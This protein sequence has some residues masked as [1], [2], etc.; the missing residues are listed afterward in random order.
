MISTDWSWCRLWQCVRFIG[1]CKFYVVSVQWKLGMKVKLHSLECNEFEQI[2]A[3][4]RGYD[5]NIY[6][7]MDHDLIWIQC[8]TLDRLHTIEKNC[9][10][11]ALILFDSW[12]G[13]YVSDD[14]MIESKAGD[15]ESKTVTDE[16]I[17]RRSSLWCHLWFLFQA[18]LGIRLWMVVDSQ[19]QNAEKWLHLLP[20]M[21]N[22]MM[23]LVTHLPTTMAMERCQSWKCWWSKNLH[24]ITVV[25][26]VGLDCNIL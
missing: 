10:K 25:H 21:A 20:E 9:L 19:M 2:F 14:E 16:N 3:T 24:V 15:V 4:P 23:F 26:E 17:S 18:V 12:N 1:W 11:G 6:L 22:N 13:C 5:P 8:N 7:I